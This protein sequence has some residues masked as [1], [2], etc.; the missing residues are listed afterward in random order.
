MGVVGST[1]L[2]GAPG[3]ARRRGRAHRR[4]AARPP[5]NGRAAGA[6]VRTGAGSRGVR[7]RNRV[8]RSAPARPARRATRRRGCAPPRT[9]R[10][11]RKRFLQAG[12][13]GEQAEREGDL[14]NRPAQVGRE[15]PEQGEHE[16]PQQT[17]CEVGKVE[18]GKRTPARAHHVV[19]ADDRHEAGERELREVKGARRHGGAR[20]VGKRKSWVRPSQRPA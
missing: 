20:R 13:I 17:G 8:Q 3:R 14:H 7:R 19:E 15:R 1:G 2:R 16:V 11:R 10:A 9:G 12:K 6:R 4:G 18:N 5:K